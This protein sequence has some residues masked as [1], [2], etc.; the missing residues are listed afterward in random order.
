MRGID[1]YAFHYI[2]V[3]MQD[4]QIIALILIGVL[5]FLV[6]RYVFKEFSFFSYPTLLAALVTIVGCIGLQGTLGRAG[7]HILIIPYTGLILAVVAAIIVAF[8]LSLWKNLTAMTSKIKKVNQNAG[9][10]QMN[11]R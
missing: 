11:H 7:L 3:I 8:T 10:D 1:H 6:I 4:V 5:N 2:G 9:K